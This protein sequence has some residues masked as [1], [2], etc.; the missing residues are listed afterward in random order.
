MLIVDECYCDLIVCTLPF[1]ACATILLFCASSHLCFQW[2]GKQH[3][4]AV[5]TAIREHVVVARG[6]SKILGCQS[7]RVGYCVSSARCAFVWLMALVVS[8][9][10]S[11]VV[12]NFVWL[13]P[14]ST[15]HSL[16][17][18][19]FS[20]CPSECNRWFQQGSRVHYMRNVSIW[21]YSLSCA[22]LSCLFVIVRWDN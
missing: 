12:W 22:F 17:S 18:H 19:P 10:V 15:L 20:V 16:L 6:F 8:F 7:W 14:K 3:Y 4:S 9:P 2:E 11:F 5:N 1:H 21:I 13:Q